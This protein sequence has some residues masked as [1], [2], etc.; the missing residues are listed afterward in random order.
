VDVRLGKARRLKGSPGVPG[1]KSLSHRALVLG[2]LAHGSTEI[3][4]LSTGDDVASTCRCLA[5][6]GVEIR[7]R[8]AAHVVQGRG[9]R[10]WNAPREPLHCGNSGSTVRMLMG[11]LAG[12]SLSCTLVGDPSLSR[13]PMSRV[14]DP[15]TRMGARVTLSEGAHAPV[16]IDGVG[17]L[18]AIDYRLEV[19]SAQVKTAILLA[20]LY[21]DGTTRLSGAI[22]S[23]DHTERMMPR[24]GAIV[25]VGPGSISLRGGGSLRAAT[26][27]IPGDPSAAAFWLAAACVV[28]EA[29]VSL[30]NIL[31]NPTR[32]GFVRVLQRMGASI[33]QRMQAHDPEPVGELEAQNA[34]LMA[35]TVEGEQVPYLIDELPMLAVLATQARG[36]T[37][38][39]GAAELRLKESD[40]IDAVAENL[41]RMGARIETFPDGFRVDGPQ[42][43][44]G[45][46]LDSFHDHRVAMAFAIAAL[47]AEGETCICNAE[48]VAISHPGFFETL[49]ELTR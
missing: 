23:R 6:M 24:F 7:A 48:S 29:R 47:C 43:L 39:R 16:R 15:L 25:D 5:A 4:G 32:T 40:R 36:S 46:R 10:G 20:A 8:G 33:E 1:D 11:A 22:G 41:R 19:A 35:V 45:A 31:L 18:S 14:A 34:A 13:R 38:V 28:P 3:T 9:L 44:K 17:G 49:A 30:S 27:D 12:Q 2:A 21:A 26:L 42:Q 37:L